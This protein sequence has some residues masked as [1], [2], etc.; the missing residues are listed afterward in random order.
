M[1][2]PIKLQTFIFFLVTILHNNHLAKA[3]PPITI[4][5]YEFLHIIPNPDGSITRIKEFFP[6][7]PPNTTTSL[8][9]SKDVPLNPYKKTWVRLYLPSGLSGPPG[10]LNNLPIVVFA[11]GGA[12]VLLSTATP[13]IDLFLSNTASKLHV[14]VVS[15]EYRLAPEHRL[16]AAYDDVLEALYWVKDK[17][18]EW[19]GKYGDVSRCIMMGESVGGNIVYNVGLRASVLT[20]VLKPLVIRGLVLIQPFYGGGN[21]NRGYKDPN[22]EVVADLLWNLS[23]PLGAN[24]NNPYFNPTFGGGSSN[25]DIIRRLGWRVAFAGCDGDFIFDKQLKVFEFFKGRGLDVIGYFG[26]GYYHGVFVEDPSES[27]KIFEFVRYVF[28]SYI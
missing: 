24:W 13:D 14:L 22:I 11:H 5:P 18:D 23:L 28:S 10:Y 26:R 21:L 3:Q 25:L 2:N 16:P 7:V 6:T 9:I 8:A 15:V 27:Q 19:V 4:N 20:R 17:K 12:F 1:K